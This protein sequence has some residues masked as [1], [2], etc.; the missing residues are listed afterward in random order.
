[1]EIGRKISEFHRSAWGFIGRLP[2]VFPIRAA[3]A[4]MLSI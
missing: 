4:R 1:M 2:A 3:A